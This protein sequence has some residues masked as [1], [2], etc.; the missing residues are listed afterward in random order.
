MVMTHQF[1]SR[2]QRKGKPRRV[3]LCNALNNILSEYRSRKFGDLPIPSQRDDKEELI[4]IPN[5]LVNIESDHI[6]QHLSGSKRSPDVLA[7]FTSNLCEKFD[8]HKDAEFGKWEELIDEGKVDQ[9]SNRGWQWN[10]IHQPWELLKPR[11]HEVEF[12]ESCEANIEQALQDYKLRTQSNSHHRQNSR[13]RRSDEELSNK[14]KKARMENESDPKPLYL[15]VA[16]EQL[17]LL[18]D[19]RCAY[20]A[21]ERLSSAWYILHSTAVLLDGE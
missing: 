4:F 19:L 11:R 15:Q 13:K 5:D 14:S 7:T 2:T 12:P 17:N 16:D 9:A 3:A 21:M 6:A 10:D 20:Y 1:S 8:N 18:P